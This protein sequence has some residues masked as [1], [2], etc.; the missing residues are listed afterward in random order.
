[1]VLALGVIFVLFLATLAGLFLFKIIVPALFSVSDSSVAQ[2]GFATIKNWL[3]QLAN[4]NPLQWIN[5]LM[6][7]G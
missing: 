1:V 4:T 6:Q 3:S 2:G 7:G 5:L